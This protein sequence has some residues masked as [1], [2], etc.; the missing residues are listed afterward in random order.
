MAW[1]THV[2]LGLQWPTIFMTRDNLGVNDCIIAAEE[3]TLELMERAA[4][5]NSSETTLLNAG[6]CA[7]SA[8]SILYTSL[9]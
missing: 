6:C 1:K 4:V 8:V 5:G 9:K 7:H 3:N 2:S